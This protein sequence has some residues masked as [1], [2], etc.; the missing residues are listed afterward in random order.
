M[1]SPDKLRTSSNAVQVETALR[2]SEQR[3]RWLAAIVESSYDA[4]ISTDIGRNIITWNHAAERLFGY[5]AEEV[6]GK[7]CYS[8]SARPP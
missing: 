3:L 6:I 2:E 7:P 4:I 1:C 8:D 5:T